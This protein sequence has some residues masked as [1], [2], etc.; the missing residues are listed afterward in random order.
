[1]H[2]VA[3]VIVQAVPSGFHPLRREVF[4]AEDMLKTRH[5]RDQE[6]IGSDLANDAQRIPCS[7]EEA[8]FESSIDPLDSVLTGWQL[9]VGPAAANVGG[10]QD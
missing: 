8:V 4:V 9:V 7:T 3:D 6:L 5:P 10:S 1:M 2:R